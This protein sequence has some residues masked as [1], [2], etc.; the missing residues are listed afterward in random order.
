MPRPENVL[1]SPYWRWTTRLIRHKD[2][3]LE[4]AADLA[5]HRTR[6]QAGKEART[7]ADLLLGTFAS[8][9]M[10][11]EIEFTP[12]GYACYLALRVRLGKPPRRG[13]HDG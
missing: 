11:Q 4:L 5:Y 3:F 8:F 13:V 9:N 6:P 2:D 7:L 1:L 12:V 10:D